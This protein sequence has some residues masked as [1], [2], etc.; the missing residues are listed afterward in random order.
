ML[1]HAHTRPDPQALDA[2]RPTEFKTLREARSSLEWVLNS[3]T[4]FFLDME[5][6]DA[7]YDIA[8]SNAEKHLVFTPWLA[9]WERAFS[10]FLLENQES[11]N[12]D[13]RGAAMVLKAHQTVAEILSEVD[14]SLGE[15]GW[16]AFHDKFEAITNLAAA[17]LEGGQQS[18]TPVIEARWKTGD[19]FISQPNATLSFSLGIVDPLYEV[20]SRC[21]SPTLRRRAL[22]LLAKHPRQECVWSSWSA[23]KVGKFL[24]RLEEEGTDTQPKSSSDI[25]SERRISGAWI[26]FSDKSTEEGRRGRVG[27]RTSIPRASARYALNP[28]LFEDWNTNESGFK[29]TDDLLSTR[30][31]STASAGRI[32]F[33]HENMATAAGARPGEP[34]TSTWIELNTLGTLTNIPSISAIPPQE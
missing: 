22:D 33:A 11:L 21:R 29:E 28:G 3:L 14:L 1:T 2:K 15:L 30:S 10:N 34:L 25:P 27:Y 6:D 20:V 4:V 7:F 9:S 5:L 18:D 23:W 24:M 8:V 31:N 26:D 32:T 12:T 19:V 13:E 16:D 17:V